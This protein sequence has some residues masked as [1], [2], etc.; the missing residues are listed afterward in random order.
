MSSPLKLE[1]ALKKMQAGKKNLA[2]LRGIDVSHLPVIAVAVEDFAKKGKHDMALAG[3]HFLCTHEQENPS[4][5]MLHGRVARIAKSYRTSIAAFM[6]GLATD[7][8]LAFCFEMART[9][10]AAN[11]LDLAYET[12]VQTKEAM[13]T[14][15]GK[16]GPFF[17]KLESMKMEISRRKSSN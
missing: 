3:C 13:D 6:T 8:D 17:A 2:S 12:V 15:K 9:Y 11:E 5:W 10:L 16:Y 7:G 4:W 1:D 14:D